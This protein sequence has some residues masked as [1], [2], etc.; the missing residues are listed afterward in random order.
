MQPSGLRDTTRLLP[1]LKSG[2]SDVEKIDE[3][4]IVFDLFDGV[5]E[6]LHEMAVYH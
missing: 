4:D 5:L 6:F 2:D 1:G 3:T